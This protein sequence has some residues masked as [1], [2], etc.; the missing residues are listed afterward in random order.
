[1]PRLFLSPPHLGPDE[2]TLLMDAIDSNW[3]APLG[4][5]VDAFEAEFA[6]TV[7]APFAVAL[8]SGT[9][10]LHLALVVAGVGLGDEVLVS[11]FTFSASVNPICYLR[12]RPVFVDSDRASWNM[13]PHLLAE[14]LSSRARAG[15]L[16]RAVIL[17][18]L[19]G[20]SADTDAVR[21]LCD[22]H[23]VI[24]IEDAAEA[25]GASYKGRA[26]GTDGWAGVC[27]FNGNKIITCSGGGMLT[28][29]SAAA[30]ERV[31]MLSTQ[32]R[33]PAPHYQHSSVGYNYRLSNLLAAVGRGQL[34]VLEERVTAR[35]RIFARYLEAL[36]HVPGVYFMP[37]E[38][39][40]SP[41]SRSTRWLTCVEF[42]PAQFGV[43]C[44][45]VR[46]AL[47]AQDIECRPVWKPMHLQPVFAE[48]DVFGGEVSS[49]IFERGL[50]L[51]SGSAMTD[52]DVDRVV[53][54]VLATRRCHAIVG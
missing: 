8:S 39:F 51:P 5:H 29:A 2:R 22:E 43:T 10:A 4:P 37:E 40:G 1:M 20:Q 38:T 16:P 9:A 30:A 49:A 28:T 19:Y 50:C 11:S 32:A 14:A 53:E 12:A 24:L 18:H 52:A 3:V 33:D 46:L 34:R 13:D 48:C 45:V 6:A 44:E 21:A 35:R 26:P 17:V 23:G 47:A 36:G 54:V 7:G 15:R 27:S 25:L 31:R 42:D 41:L